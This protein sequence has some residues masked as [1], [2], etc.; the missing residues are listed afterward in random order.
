V[1]RIVVGSGVCSHLGTYSRKK[2][3]EK[4]CA[5]DDDDTE[6]THVASFCSCIGS[7]PYSY[8]MK[9]FPAATIL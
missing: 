7:V 5:A 3:L 9:V 2:I 4:A 6:T 8:W 1:P